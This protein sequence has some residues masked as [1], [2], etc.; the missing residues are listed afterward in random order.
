MGSKRINLVLRRSGKRRFEL[1]K[2]LKISAALLIVVALFLTAHYLM[3]SILDNPNVY[4]GVFIDGCD[5]SGMS[6]SRLKSFIRDR[7]ETRLDKANMVFFTEKFELSLSYKD[8]GAYIDMESMEKQALSVGREGFF[9]SRLIKI[10]RLS[11]NPVLIPLALEVDEAQLDTVLEDLNR[12]L[13]KEVIVPTVVISGDQAILCAGESGWEIEKELLKNKI[14]DSVQGMETAYL[15]IPFREIPPP[16]IDVD[17]VYNAI[18]QNPADAEIIRGED[19]SATVKPQVNGR[20][21][22]KTELRHIINRVEERSLK[23]YEEI[24]LP[25]QVTEPEVKTRDLEAL[26]FRDVLSTVS[27]SFTTDSPNNMNRGTNIRLAAKAIDGTV[28]FPGEEFSFNGIVGPR[29]P[30]KGY[31]IAH[32]FSEGQVRD[33]YGGG[34]CQV[35]TTL[36]DAALL[37]NLKITERHN[38]MFTVGYVPLGMDAAVSYGYAD[39]KFI[40]STDYPI[41]I[42]AGVSDSNVLTFSIV[43]TNLYPDVKVRVV[44]RVVSVT[45][46]ATEY[47]DDPQM[48]EG[49]EEV[50]ENGMDGAVVDTYIRIYSGNDLIKDYKIHQSIYQMLPQKV[51]RGIKK[52]A[53]STYP[54]TE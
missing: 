53:G 36:Y 24:P 2:V 43:G 44:S 39:L 52:L 46:A 47:I 49:F 15:Y 1:K 4:N 17:A 25:V 12:Q 30:D 28:V 42:E 31:V 7:Y 14:L 51:R 33:G 11:K 16:K 45:K 6:P 48:P 8:I 22:D 13:R 29:T 26:L 23:I 38:H 34:V 37:A 40:N 9:L 3:K 20:S 32:I 21:I 27:T 18:I 5:V 41:R 50:V 10:S 35:S 54:E 19:G